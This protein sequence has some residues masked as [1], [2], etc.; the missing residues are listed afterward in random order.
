MN[1]P[2]KVKPSRLEF[3]VHVKEISVIKSGSLSMRAEKAL[4][5]CASATSSKRPT[6][7]KALMNI[8]LL[9]KP[10]FNYIFLVIQ[11]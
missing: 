4:S 10:P 8:V 6:D 7:G 1:V 9:R 5:L 11:F 2:R 3:N